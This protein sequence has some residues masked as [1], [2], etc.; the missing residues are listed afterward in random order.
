MF[1]GNL[2]YDITEERLIEEIVNKLRIDPSDKESSSSPPRFSTHITQIEFCTNERTKRRKGHVFIT[3]DTHDNAVR[4]MKSVTRDG[5]FQCDGRTLKVDWG[6]DKG[7]EEKVRVI[8]EGGE[9]RIR[10]VEKVVPYL[11]VWKGDEGRD[12]KSVV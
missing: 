4:F 10:V 2:P 1:L 8:S 7:D 9:G 11:G 12:R 6:V 3:L 5:G